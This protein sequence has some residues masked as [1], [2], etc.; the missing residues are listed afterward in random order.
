M[1][2][3]SGNLTS[4][5]SRLF[6]GREPLLSASGTFAYWQSVS[7]NVNKGT[8]ATVKGIVEELVEQQ[9]FHAKRFPHVLAFSITTSLMP[10][11]IVFRLRMFWL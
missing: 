11:Q 8:A 3:R 7:A 6:G 9:N 4:S 5:C 2:R 10:S 1:I